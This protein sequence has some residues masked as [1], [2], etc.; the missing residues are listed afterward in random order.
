[1]RA[2]FKLVVS[3]LVMLS[4]PT[5]A[6]WVV[7]STIDRMTDIEINMAVGFADGSDIKNGP[8]VAIR[9]SDQSLN[10]ILFFE[11]TR[12]LSRHTDSVSEYDL[13]FD[14]RDMT[15]HLGTAST[16][17]ASIFIAPDQVLDFISQI[18]ASN[19]LLFRHDSANEPIK[20]D[21][22]GADEAIKNACGELIENNTA[23]QLA[24]QKE[25]S[26]APL[27]PA[28]VKRKARLTNIL[29]KKSQLSQRYKKSIQTAVTKN[30]KRPEGLNPG[31]SCIATVRLVYPNQIVDVEI[32]E[33][34]SDNAEFPRAIE[35]AIYST[36]PFPIPPHKA[37]FERRLVLNFK[38]GG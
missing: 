4:T 36:I 1:M 2:I 31:E 24:T 32:T 25:T 15:S 28:E 6:E 27:T 17:R 14:R 12:R 34:S 9:C 16:D 3:G 22:T 18:N 13:R 26:A 8:A 30:F 20:I 35:K 19:T 10:A 33:C 21:L 38:P 11:S 23:Q 5:K 7:D 29:K 37:V